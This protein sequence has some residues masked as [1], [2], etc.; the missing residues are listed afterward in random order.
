MI[1]ISLVCVE[2]NVLKV[3]LASNEKKNLKNLMNIFVG[4]DDGTPPTFNP[5][6]QKL[7]HCDLD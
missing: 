2:E 6:K 5:S 3:Q 7:S 1:K 4:R